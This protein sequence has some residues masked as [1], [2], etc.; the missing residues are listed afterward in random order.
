M[1][2]G[3]HGGVTLL[4]LLCLRSDVIFARSPILLTP[5]TRH[6]AAA[7]EFSQ[8]CKNRA[9]DEINALKCHMTTGQAW[10]ADLSAHR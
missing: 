7:S 9:V 4:H 8:S 6:A 10:S 2:N 5:R 3:V 1:K